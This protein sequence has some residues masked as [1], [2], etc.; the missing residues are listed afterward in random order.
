[1]R[2]ASLVTNPPEASTWARS[3]P[4]PMN[5]EANARRTTDPFVMVGPF[6]LADVAE[7]KPAGEAGQTPSAVALRELRVLRGGPPCRF[8]QGRRRVSLPTTNSGAPT[9]NRKSAP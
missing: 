9:T 6:L 4:A 3:E 8:A 2:N 1:M 7:P 5:A